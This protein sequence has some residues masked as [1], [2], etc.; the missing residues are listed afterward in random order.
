[1][2]ADLEGRVALV[3]GGGRG[4]GR[5]AAIALAD[6]GAG[7]MAVSRTREQLETLESHPRIATHAGSLDTPAGC[8]AAVQ[9]TV[10]RFG[11]VDVLVSNAGMGSSR[12]RPIFDQDPSVWTASLAINLHASFELMRLVSPGMVDRRWGRIVVVSSTAGLVGGPSQTAYCASKHALIGLAR[13]AA[14]D[15]APYGVTCNAVCPGWVRTEMADT[16]AGVHAERQGISVDEVWEER[17]RS[18]PA[19]RV[20]QPGE[21]A[22]TI[23]F[24]AG[25]AASGIS[26]E[27]ITVAL[28]SAW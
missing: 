9:A 8:Q 22:D 24:L 20:I 5:A 7:V 28:G 10:E 13:A 16:S 3:T 15:L 11:P 2:S 19:G 26:G 14:V 18:Y 27:T 6:A 25:A 17:A 4:I 1:V 21:V 23:R 12:E